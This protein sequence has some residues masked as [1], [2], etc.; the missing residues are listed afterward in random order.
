VLPQAPF[1]IQRG[2]I[3]CYRLFD[4]GDEIDLKDVTLRLGAASLRVTHL[5]RRGVRAM[6]SIAIPVRFDLGSRTV[7]LGTLGP[8]VEAQVELHVFSY[9]TVSLCFKIP[10][11][12]GTALDA[13]A[14]NIGPLYESSDLYDLALREL[15]AVK[16][17]LRR[18]IR[19]PHD[20]P[21]CET[22]T[23]VHVQEIAGQPSA[24]Q[25]LAW[26]GLAA[27]LL[28]EVS[29]TPLSGRQRQEV[30]EYAFSYFDH[31][32]AVIDW[33]SAF[34]I[35][36]GEDS[37]MAEMLEFANSQLLNLRYHDEQLED[38]I[39]RV[40]NALSQRSANSMLFSPYSGLAHQL[41]RRL[42]DLSARIERIDNTIKV[43]GTFYLSRAYHAAIER[44]RVSVWRQGIERKHALAAS[45]YSM[46]K[47]EVETRRATWL[48][49]TVVVLILVEIVIA[50]I[51]GH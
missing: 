13:L 35:D 16:P 41:F 50:V 10:I 40:H 44:L 28:G 48:E 4:L 20:W 15:D 30:L 12:P 39:R 6:E 43:A 46:L 37:G 26:P 34:L 29:Q 2:S 8:H 22:Y 21:G 36:P 25:V 47:S 27:L 1:L 45:A 32:L 42:M 7:P 38:E 24:E 3:R 23:I 33:N 51:S 17:T 18:S 31:D 11:P 5:A 49:I 14:S 9:G 19:S